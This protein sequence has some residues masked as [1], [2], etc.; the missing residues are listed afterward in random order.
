M[1]RQPIA[2]L[3]IA[4][5]FLTASLSIPNHDTAL[6]RTEAEAAVQLLDAP[7]ADRFDESLN[8][9]EKRR[10]G[11]GSSS[12]G[13]R[14]GGSS[15]SDSSSS[16]S[17][18]SGSSS[19]G[20]GA[21]SVSSAARPSYGGGKYY[22]GGSTSAYSAGA[23]SPAGITPYLLGGAALGIFPGLWLYGAYAYPYL[24]PYSF[25]NRTAANSS[26]PNGVNQ[27]LP[28]TC[29]CQEYNPCGCD[30]NGNTTYVDSLLGNGSAS[31][32]NSSLVTVGPVNGTKTVVLN[33]TLPNG[34]STTSAAGPGVQRT[35]LESSGFWIV[36]AIVGYTVWF[37]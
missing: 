4:S 37:M 13:G 31:D 9:L 32:M 16:G 28:V 7:L 11:G 12:G 34:T 17:S 26:N 8:H 3:L 10:G 33:G 20:A 36:G 18:S 23:R 25:V 27:T 14:S 15:A 30:D 5:A 22:G 6:S 29:L 19:S 24:H 35:L 2:L 21:G 1:R